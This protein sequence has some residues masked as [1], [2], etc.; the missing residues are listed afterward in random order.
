[1]SHRQQKD[2]GCTQNCLFQTQILHSLAL[3]NE[4]TDRE[5]E[6]DHCKKKLHEFVPN[7]N[8]FVDGEVHEAHWRAFKVEYKFTSASMTAFDQCIQA[9]EGWE[10]P[11]ASR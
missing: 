6:E 9:S 2:V 4:G 11:A 1:M 3:H 5:Q 10:I 7:M 8:I